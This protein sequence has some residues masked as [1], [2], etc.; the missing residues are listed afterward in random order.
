[1]PKANKAVLAVSLQTVVALYQV[2]SIRFGSSKPTL[3]TETSRCVDFRWFF[4]KSMNLGL[5]VLNLKKIWSQL[6]QLACHVTDRPD[7]GLC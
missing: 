3:V 2:S 7:G 4:D 6:S 5:R 1:M